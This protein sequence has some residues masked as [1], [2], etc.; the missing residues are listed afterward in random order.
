MTRNVK[1]FRRIGWDIS[2]NDVSLATCIHHPMGDVKKYTFVHNLQTIN[3]I[4]MVGYPYVGSCGISFLPG[5][6]YTG[7]LTPSNDG[8]LEAG[9]WGAPLLNSNNQIIGTP[10]F[11]YPSGTTCHFDSIL[12]KFA[13]FSVAWTGNGAAD[14]RNRLDYWLDPNNTGVTT[15]AGMG[16]LLP[17]EYGTVSTTTWNTPKVVT[18]DIIIP[19]GVTLTITSVIS[20]NNNVKII[21]Q[22]GGKLIV[23]GGT[24][25][26]SDYCGNGGMWGGIEVQGMHAQSIQSASVHGAVELKNNALIEHAVCGIY[27]GC[28]S[29]TEQRAG[30]GG[31]GIIT[32][33]NSTF[34]NNL[35]SIKFQQYVSKFFTSEIQNKSNF[36]DCHFFTDDDAMFEV[37]PSTTMVWLDNVRDIR[38]NG[39][40]FNDS[41]LKNGINNCGVA[42]YANGAS[43]SMTGTGFH[44]NHYPSEPSKKNYF[45]G[46]GR[47]IVLKNTGTKAS[48]INY[49]EFKN[50]NV[51]I[52]ASISDNLSVKSCNFDVRAN[53]G[54][55]FSTG[56]HGVYLEYCDKYIIENNVFV[57]KGIGLRIQ[58][59]GV[60][61]NTV[62]WND[63]REMCLASLATDQNGDMSTNPETCTGLQFKCNRYN[64]CDEDIRVAGD[65]NGGRIRYMQGT[66]LAGA[67]NIF[68]GCN[69]NKSVSLKNFTSNYYIYSWD[70]NYH[71]PT[72]NKPQPN[73]NQEPKRYNSIHYGP[74]GNAPTTTHACSDIGYRGLAYYYPRWTPEPSLSELEVQYEG[75]FEYISVKKGYYNEVYGDNVIEWEE[76]ITNDVELMDIPQISLYVEITELAEEIQLVCNEAFSKLLNAEGF[77][78][79]TYNTWLLKENKLRSDLQLAKSYIEIS[80]WEQ[81][82]QTM[83]NVLTRFPEFSE[84]Y[85]NYM[86]CLQ[87]QYL[88]NEM[89]PL[90]V[91]ESELAAFEVLTILLSGY[92]LAQIRAIIECIT[93]N[94]YFE[95]LENACLTTFG[96]EMSPAPGNG[97][98]SIG[99]SQ[100]KNLESSEDNQY[101]LSAYPNPFGDVLQIRLDN[102]KDLNI[103][104]VSVYDISGRMLRLVNNIENTHTNI[105]LY[106]LSTGIYFIYVTLTNG[107][108]KVKRVIKE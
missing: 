8:I 2:G 5:I 49:A 93:G 57:E 107:E 14:P 4:G 68:E 3:S 23:N 37:T 36:I 84:E 32:A 19:N 103:E 1:E 91:T 62:R 11:L 52:Y 88:F 41:K 56:R 58:E 16:G 90:I 73:P 98:K 31:G 38:F 86:A 101:T 53:V 94:I 47:A 71:C 51:G 33:N 85:S 99:S 80:D 15:L 54:E 22:P 75:L 12:Y 17:T 28:S 61:N 44:P 60:G 95:I 65:V 50:N 30:L 108:T 25:T 20:I 35:K 63:F 70:R 18:G 46:F 64:W 43:I 102:A 77:D 100:P 76:L 26:K 96:G 45:E 83:N 72:P 79:E 66:P 105:Q 106:N 9:S 78:R 34:K 7:I 48:N 92:N 87:Y 81:A 40:T 39:C 27:A 21:V 10:S 74:V 42:I 82:E 29:L 67:G 13:K 97:Q 24:L 89:H 69:D 104:Q 55:D 6:F 59:S